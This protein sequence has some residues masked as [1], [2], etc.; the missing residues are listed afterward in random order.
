MKIN[1]ARLEAIRKTKKM[2]LNGFSKH[3]SLDGSTYRKIIDTGGEAVTVRS[4]NRMAGAL[5]V[6]PL[7]LLM[8]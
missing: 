5:N 4:I 1:I 6:N 2:S 7:T 3:L 8:K